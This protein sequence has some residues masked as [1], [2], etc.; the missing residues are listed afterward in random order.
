VLT[1]QETQTLHVAKLELARNSPWFKAH[2]SHEGKATEIALENNERIPHFVDLIRW[3]Y[4]KTFQSRVC[5]V[6]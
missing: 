1:D 2:L 3:M 6:A 4:C 5:L